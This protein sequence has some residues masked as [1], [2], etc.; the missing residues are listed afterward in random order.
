MLLVFICSLCYSPDFTPISVGGCSETSQQNLTVDQ[1]VPLLHM[2]YNPTQDDLGE[3]CI[4]KWLK[5]CGH[6]CG[7]GNL[8]SAV[9]KIFNSCWQSSHVG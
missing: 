6:S 3:S 8:S 1:E 4:F 2:Y 9:R 7:A 5:F